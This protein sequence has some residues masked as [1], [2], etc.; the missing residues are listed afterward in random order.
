MRCGRKLYDFT[1][2]SCL[3][4]YQSFPPPSPTLVV[5]LQFI[6]FPVPETAAP[7][8]NVSA[9]ICDFVG[10]GTMV[11]FR[12]CIPDYWHTLV[13]RRIS[14]CLGSLFLRCWLV[15]PG[16]IHDNRHH[17]EQWFRHEPVQQRVRDDACARRV[18]SERT[19]GKCLLDTEDKVHSYR[20][21]FIFPAIKWV[22][23]Q[24][25]VSK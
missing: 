1:V 19:S 22:Y 24:V 17:N 8:G 11:Q 12:Q 18:T 16:R 15:T 21:K 2:L 14:E 7:G 3:E 20:Q 25:S 9:Y 10:S 6:S 23:A 4:R 5:S 13:W